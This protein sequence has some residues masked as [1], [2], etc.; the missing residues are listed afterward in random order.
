MSWPWRHVLLRR[1]WAGLMCLLTTSRCHSDVI[2]AVMDLKARPTHNRTALGN[3][4]RDVREGLGAAMFQAPYP[5]EQ[6]R[7][8]S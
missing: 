3:R 2:Q 6:L 1:A 7:G 4:P 5:L 8:A